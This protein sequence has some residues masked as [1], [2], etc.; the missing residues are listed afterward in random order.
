MRRASYRNAVACRVRA[1]R[2][3]RRLRQR[4]ALP[5]AICLTLALFWPPARAREASK[6]DAWVAAALARGAARFAEHEG[7][8]TFDERAETTTADACR[9]VGADVLRAALLAPL[10]ADAL[11]PLQSLL[12]VPGASSRSCNTGPWVGC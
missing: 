11:D 6:V 2:V 5:V 3:F 9:T 4:A 7:C 12:R 8:G 10:G 1:G